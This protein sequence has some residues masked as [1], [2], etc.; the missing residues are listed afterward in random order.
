M[1]A[2]TATTAPARDE[3]RTSP[4]PG[5]QPLAGLFGPLALCVGAVVAAV[6]MA[7][8]LPAMPEDVGIPIAVAK[9]P[10]QWIASHL[11]MGFGFVLVALGATAALPLLRGRGAR[12]TAAGALLTSLGAVVMAL[13]D[14][15]H[16]AVAF[17]LT[18]RVEPAT[19]FEVQTAYFEQPVILGLNTGPMILMLGM[20]VLGAGLLRSHVSPRWLGALVVLT[21]IAV[22]MAFVLQLPT[23]LHGLPFVAG[24][25]AFAYVLNARRSSTA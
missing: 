24:M 22:N 20:V 17:A 19:S 3:T 13:G 25:A 16:G 5:V 8:H 10:S 1:S 7:L 2:I 11:L 18:E 4:P 9:A 23:Y 15:A 14:V 21:P 12:V 6:G